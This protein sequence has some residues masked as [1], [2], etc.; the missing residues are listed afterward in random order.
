MPSI[1]NIFKF[2]QSIID[3]IEKL[4]GKLI[5]LTLPEDAKEY[6]NREVINRFRK[7]EWTFSNIG[8]K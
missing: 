6:I 7:D 1:G 5:N 4:E 8:K 2:R 3:E